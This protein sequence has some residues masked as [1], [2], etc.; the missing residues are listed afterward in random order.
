MMYR[1]NLLTVGSFILMSWWQVLSQQ[2][3]SPPPHPPNPVQIPSQ[4]SSMVKMLCDPSD[5]AEARQYANDRARFNRSRVVSI[6]PD[7]LAQVGGTVRAAL[8]DDVQLD[9][10]IDKTTSQSGGVFTKGHV[11]G[12]PDLLAYF[13][14]YR[15]AS[16]PT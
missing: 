7:W 15:S 9:I 11:A 1:S 2:L 10:T 3:D 4:R 13:G 5:P 12:N 6:N 14:S 8:F 16:L